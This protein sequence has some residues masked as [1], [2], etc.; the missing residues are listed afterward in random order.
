MMQPQEAG[1]TCFRFPEFQTHN[2]VGL[3]NSN[4][5]FFCYQTLLHLRFKKTQTQQRRQT[6][7]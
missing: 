5:Y 4:L 1:N 3:M 2:L 7:S 6:L